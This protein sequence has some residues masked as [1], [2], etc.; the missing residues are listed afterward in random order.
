MSGEKHTPY[1]ECVEALREPGCAICRLR[2]KA[3]ARYLEAIIY[4]SVNDPRV[5]ERLQASQGFC[6]QHAWQLRRRGGALGIGIIYRDVVRDALAALENAEYKGTGR[7]SPKSV[8]ELLDRERPASATTALVSELTATDRCPACTVQAE[9]ERRYVD[10]LLEYLEDA[11]V[12]AGLEEGDGP[13]IPHLRL[14]LERLRNE[15]DFRL[16]LASCRRG[17]SRLLADLDEMIRR[18]DYRFEGDLGGVG[19]A[20]IKAVAKVAGNEGP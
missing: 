8:R 19:D 1:Y 3:V 11:E 15:G 7:L 17:L 10:V 4:E 5:R 16:L 13:C 2:D 12:R 18:H 20:W 14:S 6:R 9:A